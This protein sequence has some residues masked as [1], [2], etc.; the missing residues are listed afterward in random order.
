MT[1]LFEI[2]EV[3]ERKFEA[4]LLWW[5]I[6]YRKIGAETW[7]PPWVHSK[8]RYVFDSPEI[9]VIRHT[10]DFATNNALIQVKHAPNCNDYPTVTLQ[11]T[12]HRVALFYHNHGVPVLIAW[13]FPD[14][15]FYAN[16]VDKL[17]VEKSQTPREDL[18]G[19]RTPMVVVRKS[20]L[21]PL[22]DFYTQIG[23][24]ND[25]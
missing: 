14:D 19:S 21:E 11:E 2:G 12:S 24:K 3:A 20:Q 9:D 16:W 4:L 7:M 6:P 13:L 17:S 23:G 5:G 10:P 15:H 18:K 22:V 1:T 8:V 25:R